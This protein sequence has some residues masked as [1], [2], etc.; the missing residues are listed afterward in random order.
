MQVGSPS[1]VISQLVSHPDAVV[2][3]VASGAAPP[4][5]GAV[6]VVVDVVASPVLVV[7]TVVPVTVQQIVSST[8][9]LI[10]RLIT[11]RHSG[12]GATHTPPAAIQAAL[13]PDSGPAS[14]D[15]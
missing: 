14:L 1:Q 9:Q 15:P 12:P 11:V 2:D 8:P 3:V 4:A 10:D 6:T 5:D 13:A 7:T